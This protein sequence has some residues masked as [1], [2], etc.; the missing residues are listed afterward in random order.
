MKEQMINA[1]EEA[2]M[3]MDCEQK[4]RRAMADRKVKKQPG[5]LRKLSVAGAA[6]VL[7]MLVTACASPTVR[8]A[9]QKLLLPDIGMTVYEEEDTTTV[10]YDPESPAFAEVREGRMYFTGNG[11][12]WISR[13]RSVKQNPFSIPIRMKRG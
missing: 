6:L 3:P 5:F 1:F 10:V 8:E 13:I 9:V 4:I 11:E 7:V 12:I 2:T